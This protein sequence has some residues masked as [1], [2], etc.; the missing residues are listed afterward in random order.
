MGEPDLLRGSRR[1]T[2]AFWSR[3]RVYQRI[4]ILKKAVRNVIKEIPKAP[5]SQTPTKG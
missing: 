2:R 5:I 3:R 4:S 1:L